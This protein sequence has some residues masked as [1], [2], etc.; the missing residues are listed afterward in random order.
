MFEGN[1]LEQLMFLSI[2]LFSAMSYDS[3]AV[4]SPRRTIMPPY[5]G[6]KNELRK[7]PT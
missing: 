7:K 3:Y 6:S 1:L 5:S 2:F 4:H